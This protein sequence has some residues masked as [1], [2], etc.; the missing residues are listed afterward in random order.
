MSTD[1]TTDE[2]S[3]HYT[4]GFIQLDEPEPEEPASVDAQPSVVC[5]NCG[6]KHFLNECTKEI[7]M[8]RVSQKRKEMARE[9]DAA[10][11]KL[12]Y[13]EHEMLSQRFQP[14]KYSKEL[15]NA[16]DLCPEDLP[17][18]IYRM[19]VLGYPPGWLTYAEVEKSG[20]TIYGLDDHEKSK[21]NKKAEEVE[22]GEVEDDEEG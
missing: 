6:G 1:S 21:E 3:P 20:I 9:R 16:L 10:P 8:A 2:D 11:K 13:F 18:F 19:R 17:P 5:F 22:A 12:R 14:G 4:T 15:R 7:N